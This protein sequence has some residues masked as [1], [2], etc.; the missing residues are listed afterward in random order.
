MTLKIAIVGAGSIGFTRRLLRDILSVPEFADTRFAFQ[1]IS[2]RNLDMVASLCRREIE[3]N[4]LGA[5]IDATV[6][7]EPALSGADYVINTA[8][9]GGLDGFRTDVEIP[10]KYGVDQCVGDTICAGGP[11]VRP[12]HGS[13]DRGTCPA[14]RTLRWR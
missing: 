5:T 10:L 3:A 2:E 1:D 12:A 13:D 8:R 6:A 7:R 9:V 11:D 4:G 14:D